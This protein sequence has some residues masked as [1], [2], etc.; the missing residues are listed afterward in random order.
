MLVAIK[1]EVSELAFAQLQFD[2]GSERHM[3]MTTSP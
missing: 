3:Y 1:L 2:H